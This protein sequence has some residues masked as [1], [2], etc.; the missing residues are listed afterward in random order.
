[1]AKRYRLLSRVDP[2]TA[3]TTV[4]NRWVEERAR[5]SGDWT[6]AY[7]SGILA[8]N[9]AGFDKLATWYEALMMERGTIAGAF[10]R[11]KEEYLRRQGIPVAPRAVAPTIPA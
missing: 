11:I 6:R 3:A 2:R 10:K 1:M 5:R 8:A 4:K 9:V 7:E